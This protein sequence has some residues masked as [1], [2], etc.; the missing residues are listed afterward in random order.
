[1]PDAVD[2]M[3]SDDPDLFKLA[4][5]G[6]YDTALRAFAKRMTGRDGYLALSGLALAG[7]GGA[8]Q[9]IALSGGPVPGKC[10]TIHDPA[11]KA[12]GLALLRCETPAA[13]IM[14]PSALLPL[15]H[16]RLGLLA[17]GLDMTHHHLMSRKSFGR[18][19]LKHQ[20]VR[21]DFARVHA[22]IQQCLGEVALL[23][24]WQGMHED[25]VRACADRHHQTIT[26]ASTML[27]KLM[28]GHAFL[29]SGI[30]TLDHL[31]LVLASLYP[32][33]NRTIVRP[34]AIVDQPAENLRLEGVA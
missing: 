6:A 18:P 28:G 3:P 15:L 10:D 34:S 12:L 13:E 4:R 8:G 9:I 19:V 5:Q 32:A 14:P 26:H 33:L 17:R 2:W 29:L 7:V 21:A 25:G 1:M 16:L 31:S 20:L 23:Q 30:V 27:N 22:R 24:Q 11:L